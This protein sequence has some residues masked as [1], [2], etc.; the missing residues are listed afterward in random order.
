MVYD[1]KSATDIS[2]ALLCSS[3]YYDVI[4]IFFV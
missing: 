4:T 3:I 1:N 2:V